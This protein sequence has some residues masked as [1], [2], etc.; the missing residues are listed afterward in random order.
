MRTVWSYGFRPFFFAGSLLSVLLIIFWAMVYYRESLPGGYFD[1]INWHAHEMIYGFV[2]AI[3]AG[4]LLTA[5]ASWTQTSPVSGT[6]LMLL[7]LT[8]LVGRLA[9]AL[10]LFELPVPGWAWFVMDVLFIPGLVLALAPALIGAKV[11]RNIQ[12]LFVLSLLAL[13]NVLTHLA[14]LEVIDFTY[15]SRGIYLGVNLI[16]LIIVVI[17]GRVVPAFSSNAC[18]GIHVRKFDLVEKSVMVSVWAFVLLDFCGLVGPVTGWIA[19]VA[20][21][22]NFIRLIGWDSFKTR[23]NSLIWILHLGYFWIAIGFLLIFLSDIFQVLPRSVAIH[24]FTAGAM[25]TFI[26][27]MISRVSL[28]HTGR[29][30][31]TPNGFVW[32]FLF[33]TLSGVVRIA[34]GFFEDHYRL[35]IL[36]AGVLWATSFL[37]F[38]V[39]YAKVLLTPRPDG[40]PG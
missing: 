3:V 17:G 4:F 24:A 20:A 8:W 2:S 6:K 14:A 35:G 11:L 29:P 40:R 22:L 10:S 36:T 26:I 7:F 27:G 39:Y 33:M 16:I 18:E 23:K 5:S 30:L 1:P 25:G 9:F 34:S 13:G 37:M 12:F 19:L 32:S 38:V 21:I 31:K 15:A 28:G